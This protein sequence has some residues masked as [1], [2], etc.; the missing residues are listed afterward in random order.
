MRWIEKMKGRTIDNVSSEEEESDGLRLPLKEIFKWRNRC[1][2]LILWFLTAV[3][4]CA[5]LLL[6]ELLR[7]VLIAR[8]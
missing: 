2:L 4:V 7:I 3:C 1:T 6:C 5:G 8:T